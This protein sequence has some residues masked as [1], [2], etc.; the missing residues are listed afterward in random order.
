M[1]AKTDKKIKRVAFFGDADLP[2]N[3]TSCVLAKSTAKLLAENGYIVVNGGGPGIM[4]ASTDGAEMG[5][6][7]VEL[8]IIDPKFEPGNYEGS[9]KGN[10]DYAEKIYKTKNIHERVSKLVEIADSF[11]IFKGGTGTLAE[12]GLVWE[13]AKFEYGHHEP[14]IFVGREWEIIV[15]DIIGKMHFEE[16][17]KRVVATVETPEEV[18]KALIQVES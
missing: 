1:I 5:G 12:V 7:K 15:K 10:M 16:K 9:D 11:V 17:E 2:E 3:D 4:K 18:L 6:G 14:L 13:L 8:V